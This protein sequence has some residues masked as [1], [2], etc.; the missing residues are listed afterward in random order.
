MTGQRA[1]ND[2][3]NERFDLERNVSNQLHNSSPEAEGNE[4]FG[5]K[6][7]TGTTL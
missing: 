5:D 2:A 6:N 7:A 1:F 4:S 3:G